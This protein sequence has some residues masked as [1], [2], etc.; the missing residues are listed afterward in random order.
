MEDHT[1]YVY[2]DLIEA[3]IGNHFLKTTEYDIAE[4]T[5][6]MLHDTYPRCVILDEDDKVY[7]YL[8]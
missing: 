4:V 1:Y 7:K 5:W 2:K 3:E 8:Y 6:N